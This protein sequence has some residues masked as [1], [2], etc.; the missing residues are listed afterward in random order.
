MAE[1]VS[2]SH[3][4]EASVPVQVWDEAYYSLSSWKGYLQSFPGFLGLRMSA[5]A[6]ENGD[7]RVHTATIW[8]YPE[9]LE[10]W[11]ESTWS[12]E[13]ILSALGGEQPVYDVLERTYEDF[14]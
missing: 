12:A 7:V 13:A 14:A 10:A 11:R 9:Q 4:T 3:V 8:E 5:Y 6:L 2:Y 1:I